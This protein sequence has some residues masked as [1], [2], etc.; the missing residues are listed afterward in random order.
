MRP[1][2]LLFFLATLQEWLRHTMGEAIVNKG[3]AF[4]FLFRS[5][6]HTDRHHHKSES[7]ARRAGVGVAKDPDQLEG[8]E[9][10]TARKRIATFTLT[11]KGCKKEKK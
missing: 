1:V 11:Y 5:S 8:Q 7:R 6:V 3:C 9:V 4:L 2:L 10:I